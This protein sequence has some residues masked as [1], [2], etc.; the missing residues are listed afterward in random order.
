MPFKNREE[1]A[2]LLAKALISYKGQNPLVL[3][4]PRGAAPMAR[5]IA[6]TLDGEMDVVLVH[7]ISAPF[8]EEFAIGSVDE[9]GKIYLNPYASDIPKDYIE[10][11]R[12]RQLGIIH[13]R[14]AQ[15]TKAHV[16]PSV[17]DRIVIVVD[18]GIATGATMIA[19]LKS[20][21]AQH[22]KQ[23]IAATAVGPQDTV[24]SIQTLADQVVCL[25]TP[26]NFNAVG[27]FLWSFHKLLM[28]K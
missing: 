14:R 28:T 17:K 8:Q 25:L 6:D 13:T 19:A 27:Q 15:Y 26:E 5:I 20:L 9:Q 4:I 23:L 12:Q 2:Q 7:K 11:E 10:Q 16:S 24:E 22:P 21:R 3:A 1:A 18:D